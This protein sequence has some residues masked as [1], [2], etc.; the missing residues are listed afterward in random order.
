LQGIGLEIARQLCQSGLKVILGCRNEELG[1]STEKA[2]KEEGYNVEFRQLDISSD[3]SIEQFVD[4]L[5]KTYEKIDVLVNNAAIAFKND[6]PTPFAQQAR[7]TITIN[8]F[9]TLHLTKAML[10]LLKNA[11]HPRI[12]N[13]ASESGHLRIIKTS[14]LKEQ[15]VSENL[16]LDALNGLMNAFLADVESGHH[17]EAGWPSTCY[18]M[19]KLAVIAFTKILAK[20]EPHVLT[21]ACCPG[22][23]DT[24]MTSH[25]G[26]R[27]AV[28]GAK[29][30]ALLALLPSDSTVT[31]AFYANEKE[32]EW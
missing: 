17:E 8:Y 5:S 18:G 22:Y 23:C 21:N 3:Q 20:A 15:F 6:D 27:P 28:E 26:P 2:L 25:K 31:G 7:P 29:T 10:P 19:S 14:T 12:V 11:P 13:V 32:I 4:S 9:G 16:T 30:P 24:D 1:Q